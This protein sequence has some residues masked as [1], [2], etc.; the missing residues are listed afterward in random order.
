MFKRLEGINRKPAQ[1]VWQACR[2][3]ALKSVTPGL[4]P[5]FVQANLVCVPRDYAYDFLVFCLR[6]PQACPL[7]D[8]TEAGSP[9]PSL[10][11]VGA[12]LRTDLPLYRVWKHGRVEMEVGDVSSHWRSDLVSFLLGCSFSWEQ[13]LADAGYPPR[14]LQVPCNV[15]MYLTNVPNAVSGG[16]AGNLVV[17]MRPYPPAHIDAVSALTSNYPAAHGAPV[18]HGDPAAIGIEDL[19][20]PDYGGQTSAAA[21]GP[22]TT[23]PM[24]PGEQPVFWACGVTPQSALEAAKLPFAITHSPGHMFVCDLLDSEVLV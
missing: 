3:G 8:V 6:N 19:Q 22:S 23:V 5:G 13:E 2:S 10:A 18:H 12:D 9:H 17:S 14:H 4:A 1:D 16:F 21:G 7:L 11:A 20:H 24:H 15:P